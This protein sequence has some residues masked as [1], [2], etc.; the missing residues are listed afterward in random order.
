M[1]KCLFILALL[2]NDVFA[3]GQANFVKAVVI[4]NNGDSIYG[5][6]DYRNWKN[7]PQ[8]INFIN[9]ANEKQA[10]DASS[11]KGFYVP[12]ANE[13]YTSFTV[14]M[15]MISDDQY[16]AM[17]SSINNAPTLRKRVFPSSTGKASG[18]K[19]IP[20]YR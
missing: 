17:N 1:R 14:E 19:F 15:D 20:V 4:N 10:F 18:I 7:N 8:T 2:A 5:N 11:I 12:A 9:A 13:T 3:S 6:I 16:E